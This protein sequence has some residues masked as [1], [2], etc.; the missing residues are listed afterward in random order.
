MLGGMYFAI[1]EDRSYRLHLFCCLD[2]SGQ[3][4]CIRNFHIISHAFQESELS[5]FI[6]LLSVYHRLNTL[7][8]SVAFQAIV[9]CFPCK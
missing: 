7:D 2:L 3:Y 6:F 8:T 4:R 5:T 9:L 1:L